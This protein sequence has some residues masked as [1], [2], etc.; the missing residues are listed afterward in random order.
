MR[1]LILALLLFSVSFNA[2]AF[3][4][5]NPT[6]Q[7]LYVDVTYYE[8]MTWKFTHGYLGGFKVTPGTPRFEYM[9]GLD[10]KKFAH[11]HVYTKYK[12]VDGKDISTFYSCIEVDAYTTAAFSAF[13]DKDGHVKPRIDRDR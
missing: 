7:T 6:E 1:K 3:T 12:T 10:K 4:A 8:D 5:V 2:L 11:F 13:K 9:K